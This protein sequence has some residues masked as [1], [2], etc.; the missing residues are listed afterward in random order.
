MR[1]TN[2]VDVQFLDER[3][4]SVS[5]PPSRFF[6]WHLLY[7]MPDRVFGVMANYILLAGSIFASVAAP[8][9]AGA[10]GLAAAPSRG[11]GFGPLTVAPCR[12]P[13]AQLHS[14]ARP[15]LPGC[16]ALEESR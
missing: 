14:R 3:A 11:T 1:V 2:W 15:R 12:P 6:D 4:A 13:R 5:T 9:E 16:P 10:L 7:A 8:T